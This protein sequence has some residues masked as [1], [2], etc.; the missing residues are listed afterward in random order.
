MLLGEVGSRVLYWHIYKLLS[1]CNG[2][3]GSIVGIVTRPLAGWF[4][5]RILEGW[6]DFFLSSFQT[7]SGTTLFFL[8][9]WYQGTF[10]GLKQPS[11][12]VNHS[13]LSSA[14][15]KNEWNYTSASAKLY[16]F[17]FLWSCCCATNSTI[18]QHKLPVVETAEILL[19]WRY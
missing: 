4:G 5:F 6:G 7:C 10:P 12:E 14:K 17:Q 2:S 19:G 8:F 1:I 9:S 11:Y 16:L 3:Q 15:A 18:L 13:L